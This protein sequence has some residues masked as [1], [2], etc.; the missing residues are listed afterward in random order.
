MQDPRNVGVHERGA[1]FVG[2]R[3]DGARRIGA[4]TGQLPQCGG[5]TGNDAIVFT[6]HVAREGV[7]IPC[8]RIVP[9]SLP[10][11]HHALWAR[12]GQRIESGEA[13]KKSL[14]KI[15]H[16]GDLS[17]LQHEFGHEHAIRIAGFAPGEIAAIHAIPGVQ[18]A[19]KR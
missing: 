5:L 9:E 11:F 4:D 12:R 2:E 14:V 7:Q 1:L 13:L 16:A 3:G 18:F 19:P 6:G 8:A 10:R 17:L 15:Q